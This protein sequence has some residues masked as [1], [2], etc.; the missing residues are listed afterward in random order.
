MNIQAEKLE[1]MRLLLN[2][3]NPKVISAIKQVF[4][5]EQKTDFWN[6]LSPEQQQEIKEASAEIDRGETSDYESF[7]A[8]HRERAEL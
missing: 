8:K 6:E 5:N 7:M 2:T 3:D 4:R 1:I